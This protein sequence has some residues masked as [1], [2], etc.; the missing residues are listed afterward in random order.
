[1]SFLARQHAPLDRTQFASA[2]QVLRGGFARNG[3]EGV[4]QCLETSPEA[5]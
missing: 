3:I 4:A 1:M 2:A 5:Q